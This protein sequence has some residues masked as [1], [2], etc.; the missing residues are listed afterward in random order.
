MSFRKGFTSGLESKIGTQA[1]PNFV[2]SPLKAMANRS[3]IL[4]QIKA[5]FASPER[6]KEIERLRKEDRSGAERQ[7]FYDTYMIR[8][9]ET[10]REAAGAVLGTIAADIAGDGMRN[11][12]WF[13][14]APQ[15][16]TQVATQQAIATG[17]GRTVQPLIETAPLRMAATLPAVL[18]ISMGMGQYGREPGFKAAVPSEDDPRQTADPI[19]EALTRYF[20][21]RSGRLLPYDEFVKERPDVSPEEY[22]QYKRY[23]FSNQGVLKATDEGVLGPEVAFMGKSIPISTALAP[24]VAGIL[25]A[26]VGARR[27]AQRFKNDLNVKGNMKRDKRREIDYAITGE[28]LK[29]GIAA[30]AGTALAGQVLESIRRQMGS[31]ET[32]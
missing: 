18:G 12:W 29:S 13:I 20:L 28:I 8:D 26:G 23:L 1:Q 10:K 21:G 11:I 16:L 22:R 3:H 24:A 31:G 25:G 30:T 27:G 9:A 4:A 15:A 6:L 5:A 7:A 14:N 17:A 32:E 2:E 19:N